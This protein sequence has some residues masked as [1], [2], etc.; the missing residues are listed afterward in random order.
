MNTTPLNP[1][2]VLP[3]VEQMLYKLAWKTAQAYPITFD[4]AKAEAYYAFVRACHDYNP[5]KGSK[6]SSWIY[7]WVWTHLKTV[8]TKRTV[9]PL[10]FVEI[11]DDLCGEAPPETSPSLELVEEMSEDAKE[12]ISLLLE[13]PAEILEEVGLTPKQLLTRVKSYL[14]SRGKSKEVVDKAD[15]EIRQRFQ[16]AWA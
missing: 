8:I 6:P 16:E 14:V 11:D 1:D 15:Q 4:E 5:A 2:E 9:D 12:I 7:F 3:T 13:T 10:T